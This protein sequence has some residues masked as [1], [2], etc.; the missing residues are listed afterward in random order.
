VAL[1]EQLFPRLIAAIRGDSS[2]RAIGSVQ[3][4]VNYRMMDRATSAIVSPTPANISSFS[5]LLLEQELTGHLSLSGPNGVAVEQGAPG[6]HWTYNAASVTGVFLRVPALRDI[7]ARWMRN[8]VALNLAFRWEGE[9]VLPAPRVKDEKGQ[10]PRDGY[11][12]VWTALAAG[13]VSRELKRGEKFYRADQAIACWAMREAW[14]VGLMGQGVVGTTVPKLYLPILRRELDGGGFLA[15]IEDT[16]NARKAMGKDGCNWVRCAPAE[17]TWGVDW[18]PLPADVEPV[19]EPEHP[20]VP[21]VPPLAPPSPISPIPPVSSPA[22]VITKTRDGEPPVHYM[23]GP[24]RATLEAARGDL[25]AW[26]S[27]EENT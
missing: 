1:H 15:W 14:R 11:R 13:E 24:G 18:A 22:T 10:G 21:P 19:P 9:T 2:V 6:M 4:S 3:G 5:S 8:E 27:L 12:D 23:I 20:P 17:V 16:P 26:K 7:C 25:A